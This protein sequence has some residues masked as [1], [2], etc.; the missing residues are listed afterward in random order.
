MCLRLSL[1][2]SRVRGRLLGGSRWCVKWHWGAAEGSCENGVK[3]QSKLVRIT[4]WATAA[5]EMLT[6]V[7]FWR[8]LWNAPQ[9]YLKRKV[10]IHWLTGT[11][12]PEGRGWGLPLGLA[13]GIDMI[14]VYLNEADQKMS[15]HSGS[16]HGCGQVNK[17]CCTEVCHRPGDFQEKQMRQSH[18]SLRWDDD[19]Y[20]EI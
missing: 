2:Q 9:N 10:C 12:G 16:S 17:L 14:G 7:A 13:P 8:P 5:R 4:E 15:C 19:T 18:C 3:K 20:H 1:P 6:L 11:D